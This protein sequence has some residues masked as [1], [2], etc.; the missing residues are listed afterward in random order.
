MRNIFP[1]LGTLVIAAVLSSGC[2]STEKKLGRGMSNMTEFVRLGEI[3]RSV[4]QTALFDQ[5]GGHYA[6]GF[7]RGFAKSVARTGVGVYEVVRSCLD[8]LPLAQPGVSGR[9]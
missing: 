8:Q 5:P 6:T 1:F 9:L 7:V 3:Q 2:S 4:E